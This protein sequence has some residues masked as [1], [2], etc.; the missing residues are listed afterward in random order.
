MF[1]LNLPVYL[2]IRT[3]PNAIH[4]NIGHTQNAL[5]VCSLVL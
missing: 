2:A 4:I 5:M 3:I 1:V